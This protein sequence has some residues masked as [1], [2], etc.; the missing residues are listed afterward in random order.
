MLNF[1]YSK[2][3]YIICVMTSHKVIMLYTHLQHDND[4]I[5][6]QTHAGRLL[7]KYMYLSLYCKGSKRVTQGLR[8]RGSWRS[9]ITAI[10]WPSLLWPSCCV[11]LVLL[12]LNRRSRGP[13]CWVMASITASYQQLLW[14]PN[15]IRVPEGPLGRVWFYLPHLVFLRLQCYWNSIWLL[16][17]ILTALYNSSTPT[18]SPTR[19]LKSNV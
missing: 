14:S 15:S 16:T 18:R 5:N 6:K 10:F 17:S 12:M 1:I 11:F 2:I 7:Y 19:S 3:H 8:V 4:S 13:H 9:N